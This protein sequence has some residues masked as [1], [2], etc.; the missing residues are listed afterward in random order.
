MPAVLVFRMRAVP[1]RRML[2]AL[3]LCVLGAF[4]PSCAKPADPTPRDVVLIVLD[5]LR[6]DHLS[7]YGYARATSPNLVRFA[8]AAVTYEDAIAP[9]TWTTPSHASFF[10]GRWP[11]YHGAERVAGDRTLATPVNPDAP[12]LAELLRAQGMHT[13]AFVANTAYVA[14]ALGFDRGFDE[15]FD[16]DL[17]VATQVRDAFQAWISTQRGRFFVFMNILDPHEPYEPPRPYDTLF[18]GKRP[19]YGPNMTTL[20]FAG[21]K[22]TPEMIAH[23]VSQYDGEIALTDDAL[24][25]VFAALK[26]AG[27][28]DTALIIV[29]SDH[30]ELLGEHGLAGHGQTPYEDLVRIPLVVKY[31]G[32]RRAGERIARRVSAT[33]V[34]AT[35]L[36]SLGVPYPP[37]MQVPPLDEPHAVWVEDVAWGGTRVRVGYDGTRKLVSA[38]LDGRTSTWLYDLA[39]DASESEPMRDESG[40][41]DL[42]AALAA[43][44]DA[45]RPAYVAERPVIDPEREAKL[46]ALGYLQ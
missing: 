29:T 45:P 34:F 4:V 2:A 31:P 33:A 8:R 7:L 22:P 21:T 10:T 5:T 12:V 13:A 46:R 41:P 35:I 44:A 1:V 14:R 37:G 40:A 20:V 11:S 3:A 26:N 6:A 25:D 18:P 30:G 36:A 19:E 32:S 42:R 39:A 15:F 28:Y 43:F 9:G 38:T 16:R 27:R 23:F 24:A 17:N